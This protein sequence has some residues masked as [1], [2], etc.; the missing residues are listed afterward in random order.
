V[1]AEEANDVAVVRVE[2][3][4]VFDCQLRSPCECTEGRSGLLKETYLAFVR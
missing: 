4:S 1:D 2:E 3:L